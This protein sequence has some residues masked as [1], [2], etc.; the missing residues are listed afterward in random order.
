MIEEGCLENI[1]EIYGFHNLPHFDEGDIRVCEGGFF[2][3]G[4]Q[5][6]I[7]IYGQGGH[8]SAPH[9]CVQDVI[10]ATAAV[11]N[12]LHTIKSRSIDSREN[13]IIS[14]CAVDCGEAAAVFPDKSYIK[15]TM[16][17]YNDNLRDK[18]KAK[19]T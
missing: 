4:T 16:R 19:I 1:D 15:G 3:G 6:N 11:L 9:K 2:A 7:H 12:S 17:Y 13:L 18:T 5:I 10:V 14:I 8:G